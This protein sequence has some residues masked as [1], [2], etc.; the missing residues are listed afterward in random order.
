MRQKE[1]TSQRHWFTNIWNYQIRFNE[2]AGITLAVCRGLFY[3][4]PR[5]TLIVGL[6][7]R[8]ASYW[9]ISSQIS[10]N[11]LKFPL[12][13]SI[14]SQPGWQAGTVIATLMITIVIMVAMIMMVAMVMVILV[15]MVVLLINVVM[16]I[17]VVIV[18]MVVMVMDKTVIQTWLSR[19][20]V[21]GSYRNSCN[22]YSVFKIL[23]TCQ[24][25]RMYL[26][27]GKGKELL[28]NLLKLA[29]TWP[30]WNSVVF[31]KFH[32]HDYPIPTNI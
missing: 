23:V 27:V 21:K 31:K 28:P 26:K 18:I 8:L 7:P 13:F 14:S 16:L 2:R 4:Q 32:C 1:W 12:I 11:F 20:L 17:M 3:I 24:I 15:I 25:Y 9:I 6:P 30:H 19:K 5:V 29:V 10:P 22:V